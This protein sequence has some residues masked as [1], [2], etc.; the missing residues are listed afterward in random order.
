MPDNSNNSKSPATTET[1][2][3]TK[4]DRKNSSRERE[5]DSP[6]QPK[7]RNTRSRNE[8]SQGVANSTFEKTP[9]SKSLLQ[10]S[11]LNQANISPFASS[12][13]ESDGNS[14]DS[15]A[16]KKRAKVIKSKCPCNVTSGGKSWLLTCS[17]CGQ[18]WHSLCANLK[19][20]DLTQK[21]IDSLLPHWQCPWCFVSPYPRPK[22]H[23]SSKL[24]NSLQTTSCANNISAQVI[25][26]L[27]ILIERKLAKITEPTNLL[28]E[29]IQSQLSELTKN[30]TDL[31]EWPP[32]HPPAEREFSHP[33]VPP[34]TTP[35][36]I[37]PINLKHSTKHIEGLHDNFITKEE[38]TELVNLFTSEEFVHEGERGVL[39]YGEHYKYMGSNT[40]P[41]LMPAPVKKIMDRLNTEY[42]SKHQEERFHFKLN[43]CLVNRYDNNSVCLPEHADNEGDIDPKSSILTLSL[44]APRHLNFADLQTGQKTSLLC[45]SRSLYEMTRHS[46]DFFKHSMSA[47]Q[48]SEETPGGVRYSLTF[49]ALHWSN[50]NSTILIGDSNFGQI[51]FGE[52]KG[53]VGGSTPGVRMWAPTIDKVD[54]LSCTS[55]RNV[56]LMVGT[57]NLKNEIT[58]EE[59][60]NLYRDYK[61]K[62]GLIRKYNSKCRIFICPV[63]PTKSHAINRR[64]NIFNRFIFSDLV[65]CATL[66]VVLV[67]GFLKFLDKRTNRLRT[68]MSRDDELHLNKKGVSVLVNYVKE[69]IFKARRRNVINSPRSYS[70]ALRGGPSNPV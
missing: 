56:V 13:S 21:G 64:I 48:D 11:L 46:Q 40:K 45:K 41:K 53:K 23:K 54:P 20:K 17:Q 9:T 1:N 70:N 15:T 68:D 42:G 35:V 29:S 44:G 31:K 38:E 49:R 36:D 28:V 24:E 8:F 65:Q 55:F 52:G 39:Q 16:S 7:P 33:L 67:D 26:S 6:T 12:F 22:N 30:I 57:N 3:T 69:S 19:G 32:H 58:D 37:G 43:S 66:K 27:E 4:K 2:K 62:V 61:T 25:D 5:V 51:K 34:K 50:F 18:V 60:K 63:L 59:I 10:V 47:E 14:D